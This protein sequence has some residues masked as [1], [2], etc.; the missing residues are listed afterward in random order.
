ML[1]NRERWLGAALI[2]LIPHQILIFHQIGAVSQ[3]GG[4]AK[5]SYRKTP[6][7][8]VRD[9][10]ASRLVNLDGVRARANTAGESLIS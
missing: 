6:K 10:F 8:G 2:A 4:Q 5:P 7:P 9:G 1:P 3:P